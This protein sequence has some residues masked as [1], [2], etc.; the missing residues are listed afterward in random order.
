MP[1]SDNWFVVEKI[2]DQTFV[3]KEPGH[4]EKFNAYLL[5]SGT[6]ACLIDTG[7][8][9]GNIKE[10]CRQLTDNEIKVITT[11][12]HWDHIGGHRHFSEIYVH[13]AEVDWMLNG[14][15]AAIHSAINSL[16]PDHFTKPT[17][18][19]FDLETYQVFQ[20][21]PKH[22]LQDQDII[23]IGDRTLEILHTPGHSPGHICIWEA[24]R[25]Y[26]FS[27]DLLY[28][29]T[30]YLFF[31]STDPLLFTKSIDRIAD[32]EDVERIFPSHNEPGFS[33]AIIGRVQSALEILKTK[34]QLHHGAG[35]FE[36][37]DF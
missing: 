37:S 36:F 16:K 20:G 11:H 25:G 4:W 3:I 12:T 18:V 29:G 13:E 6:D 22:I 26:L 23:K 33:P 5:I 21:Q 30:L 32:L 9:V 15:P 17:P 7:L 19:G 28:K 31:E 14:V 8:G 34:G 1:I 35:L 2:D 24:D 27:G 10:L